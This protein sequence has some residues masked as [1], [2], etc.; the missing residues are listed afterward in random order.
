MRSAIDTNVLS[1]LLAA[2]PAATV[3]R[4]LLIEARRRGSLVVCAVVYAE[5]SAIRTAE[6]EFLDAF[7]MEAGIEVES[8]FSLDTLFRAGRAYQGYSIRRKKSGG[9][10]PRRIIPD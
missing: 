9:E 6:A 7:L 8:G 10:E 3:A 1:A 4:P 5:L 2:Q